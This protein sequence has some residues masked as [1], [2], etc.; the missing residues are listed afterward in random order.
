MLEQ[1]LKAAGDLGI[2]FTPVVAAGFRLEFIREM[3]VMEKGGKST[4][5]IEQ[6]FLFTCGE[7][8]VRG[9]RWVGGLH[10]KEWVSFLASLASPG[11]EDGPESP[12]L[13]CVPECESPAGDIDGRTDAAGEN[14]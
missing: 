10:K 3:A 4:V 13:R 2:P 6:R 7:I 1:A 5:G 12:P 8:E 9:L 14:K 11:A